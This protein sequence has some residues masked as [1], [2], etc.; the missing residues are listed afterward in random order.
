MQTCQLWGLKTWSAKAT[1]EV[2][3]MNGVSGQN[4]AE[5]YVII[6]RIR[7]LTFGVLDTNAGAITAVAATDGTTTAKIQAGNANTLMAIYGVP[8]NQDF[9]M[10]YA[11]AGA[12]T[13]SGSNVKVDGTMWANFSPDIDPNWWVVAERFKFTQASNWDHPYVPRKKFTGPCMIKLQVAANSNN[14]PVTGGFDGYLR[15]K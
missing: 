2:V 1:S 14:T 3:T 7:G 5:S 12:L 4:T 13:G 6:F 9:Y 11:M 15:D 8:D 10:T